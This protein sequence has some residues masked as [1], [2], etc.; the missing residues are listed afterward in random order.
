MKATSFAWYY[1][2]EHRYFPSLDS[3]ARE[4]YL[5][6]QTVKAVAGRNYWWS[7]GTWYCW[8]RFP[9]S[10]HTLGTSLKWKV[11]SVTPQ[12]CCSPPRNPEVFFQTYWPRQVTKC[13]W[14]N[15]LYGHETLYVQ[16]SRHVEIS[17]KVL[18]HI[19]H[20][21]RINDVINVKFLRHFQGLS[22]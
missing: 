4:R 13:V 9:T 16:P 20:F 1:H 17:Q 18:R 5:F 7:Q 21:W 8:Q 2:C 19:R 10:R 11:V 3:R 14:F 15:T 6:L 12:R 22:I